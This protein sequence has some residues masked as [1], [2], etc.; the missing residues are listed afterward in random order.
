MTYTKTRANA[1]TPNTF[2]SPLDYGAKGDGVTNDVEALRLAFNSG[3][4]VD[5]GGLTYFSTGQITLTNCHSITNCTIVRKNMRDYGSECILK[6]LQG[7]FTLDNITFNWGDSVFSPNRAGDPNLG[8]NSYF[9]V[10]VNAEN[11]F[12][13]PPPDPGAERVLFSD[14]IIRNCKFTGN[15]S[16]TF[17][18]TNHC[19]NFTIDNCHVYDCKSSVA[20]DGS[21]TNIDDQIQG[22][23]SLNCYD[24][25]VSNCT[26]RNLLVWDPREKFP[27]PVNP[28]EKIDNNVWKKY[29]NNESRGFSFSYS[30]N[31]SVIGCHSYNVG[32]GFDITGSGIPQR[33]VVSNC[34]ADTCGSIGFKAAN[35]PRDA[36]FDSC[37]AR[38]IGLYAYTCSQTS[39]NPIDNGDKA[40]RYITFNNCKAIDTGYVTPD[41]YDWQTIGVPP[42]AFGILSP[43]GTLKEL[44]YRVS[45]NNCEVANE[46]T[47][48]VLPTAFYSSLKLDPVS[49]SP[50]NR[51]TFADGPLKGVVVNNPTYS[52]HNIR[53]IYTGTI[54]P[55]IC[56]LGIKDDIENWL[57]VDDGAFYPVDWTE[58]I[59]DPFNLQGK[60]DTAN[61]YI[62][63]SGYYTVTAQLSVKDRPDNIL[64]RLHSDSGVLK[65]AYGSASG[66]DQGVGQSASLNWT[67]YLLAGKYVRAEGLVRFGTVYPGTTSIKLLD[68]SYFNITKI[69]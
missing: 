67:G 44:P 59:T 32:Q 16:G 34:T 18:R 23:S 1:N 26:A 8:I 43:S 20:Q 41:H 21:Q 38:N 30:Q 35:F 46:N 45:I 51:N 29:A 27:D 15:G 66:F 65:G 61:V 10:D 6:I 53:D 55:M 14:F 39:Y 56:T 24:F 49:T 3:K 2:V 52:D 47:G 19:H 22:I 40:I 28:G 62:R 63:Q 31:F 4:P 48:W 57:T 12:V 60:D 50:D 9:A 33:F 68:T 36:I 64:L 17:L 11:N 25:T 69:A 13:P 58:K 54:G 42:R 37:I 5:G 7:N